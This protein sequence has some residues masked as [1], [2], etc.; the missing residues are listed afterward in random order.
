[1][2]IAFSA[3]RSIEDGIAEMSEAEFSTVIIS[4]A[5]MFVYIA[6]ALGKIR[7]FRSL[8]VMFLPYYNLSCNMSYKKPIKFQL[9]S[10]ITLAFGGIII[11]LC[12][13]GCS[14]G[15]FGYLGI[16]TT[17]LTI[18]VRYFYNPIIKKKKHTILS[19]KW[20]SLFGM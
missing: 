15:F 1:M 10:K 18:E 9:E 19:I 6:I 14:L 11:V 3:E 8:L 4:Y 7:S 13:V 12:S 17:L 2:E 5:I 16:S 20:S